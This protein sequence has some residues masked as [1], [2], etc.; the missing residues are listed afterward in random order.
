MKK[1]SII[2]FLIILIIGVVGY[3][4]KIGND[5]LDHSNTASQPISSS[6]FSE[7]VGELNSSG[8]PQL[9]TLAILLGTG[10]VG[11]VFVR[12]K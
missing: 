4:A 3:A 1:I 11:I 6:M 12:R 5:Y 9:L 7:N 2:L 10:L 8:Q